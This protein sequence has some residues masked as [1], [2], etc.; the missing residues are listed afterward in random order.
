MATKQKFSDT[1][2]TFPNNKPA[3]SL[4]KI[5]MLVFSSFCLNKSILFKNKISDVL[6]ENHWLLQICRNNSI[7]SVIRFYKKGGFD[8]SWNLSIKTVGFLSTL[9]KTM[10]PH[11]TNKLSCICRKHINVLN[12]ESSNHLHHG[13][14]VRLPHGHGRR[15]HVRLGERGH[16]ST[17]SQTHHSHDWCAGG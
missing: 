7:D 10:K 16:C 6:N 15:A 8:R 11:I 17:T 4:N 9:V 2:E 12:C 13:H 3:Y 14:G 1:T 5:L